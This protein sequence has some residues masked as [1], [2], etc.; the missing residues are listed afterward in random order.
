MAKLFQAR[1]M[2]S[3][4]C[5]IV[6]STNSGAVQIGAYCWI[7]R[8]HFRVDVRWHHQGLT[9]CVDRGRLAKAVECFPNTDTGFLLNQQ[10]TFQRRLGSVRIDRLL[11]KCARLITEPDEDTLHGKL[12]GSEQDFSQNQSQT[13]PDQ[14]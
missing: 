11:E 13:G 8:R 6:A 10:S 9:S 1:Y 4:T 12:P 5:M 14:S 2:T 3:D 7:H